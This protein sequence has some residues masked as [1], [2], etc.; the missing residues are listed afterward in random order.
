LVLKD[1]FLA[2]TNSWLHTHIQISNS[3]ASVEEPNPKRV[4][5]YIYIAELPAKTRQ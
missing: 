5:K 3:M 2:L 4:S 1:F